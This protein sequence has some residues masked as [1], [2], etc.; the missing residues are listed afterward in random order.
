LEKKFITPVE[1]L[2]VEFRAEFFNI[3]NHTNYYLP[4]GVSIAQGTTTATAGVGGS[5]PVS[6]V[7]EP[8][9]VVNGTTSTG[10]ISTTYEPRIIQFGLKIIY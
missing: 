5:V 1:G 2:N 8:S 4:G 6:S 7:A 9:S 3:F 10:Q